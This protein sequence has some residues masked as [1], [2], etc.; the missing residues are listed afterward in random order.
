MDGKNTKKS[1]SLS[2]FLRFYK[3]KLVCLQS[4]SET[5]FY[6][7]QK[8]KFLQFFLLAGLLC[9]V[10]FF[11]LTADVVRTA[12]DA[13]PYFADFSQFLVSHPNLALF[14]TIGLALLEVFL[15]FRYFNKNAFSEEN[16]FMPAC[17][18][19]ALM[20]LFGTNQFLST[21]GLTNLVILLIININRDSQGS[22]SKNPVFISG[23]LLG[24]LSLFD[25][26]AAFLFIYYIL[27]L[28]IDRIF[29][30][31]DILVAIVGVLLPY[32]YLFAY[33]FF[34]ENIT[35]YWHTISQIQ[36]HF[37]LFEFKQ[38]SVPALIGFGFFI[39]FLLYIIIKLKVHYDNKL[40]ILRKRMLLLNLLS[41]FLVGV[42][43][44]SNVPFPQSVGYLVVPLACYFAAYIPQKRIVW[45][46][47]ITLTLLFA[48]LVVMVVL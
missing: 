26:S 22:D 48:A 16:T 13:F 10:A 5:M 9:A 12:N 42:M 28:A 17:W 25:W 7:F 45:A 36:F 1:K 15:I 44:C 21:V 6:L 43:V 39:L 34:T 30:V 33:Q 29:K 41:I 20:L 3:K 40:M 38:Y 23:I 27:V 46:H 31:K 8:I 11:S 4:I 35:S 32:T 18:L 19:L 2:P 24:L 47:E 14:C 37:P